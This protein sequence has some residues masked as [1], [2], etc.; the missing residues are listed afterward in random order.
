MILLNHGDYV[1]YKTG[2]TDYIYDKFKNLI[3]TKAG[4]T[5]APKFESI[6]R[7]NPCESAKFVPSIFTSHEKYYESVKPTN[8]PG[9]VLML[10]DINDA[11]KNN[12]KIEFDANI[13]IKVIDTNEYKR[14]NSHKISGKVFVTELSFNENETKHL[15]KVSEAD[16]EILFKDKYKGT[17]FGT[18]G[19]K[20]YKETIANINIYKTQE[21]NYK[22]AH[23]ITQNSQYGSY[24]SLGTN[25]RTYNQEA[26]RTG[27]DHLIQK[28]E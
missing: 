6:V 7:A 17:E 21:A 10:V 14:I 28:M 5:Y 9:E 12:T 4:N 23:Q 11:N 8:T 20:L 27:I 2:D 19:Y 18:I 15:I 16:L 3:I 1:K 13:Y 24:G 22:T 25:G 26:Y